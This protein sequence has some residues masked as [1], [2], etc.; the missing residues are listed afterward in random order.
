MVRSME[1]IAK[2]DKERTKEAPLH[3]KLQTKC[4]N[5][6]VH[7]V[8][9][10][11]KNIRLLVIEIVSELSRNLVENTNEFLPL[12]NTIWQPI[13]QRF[14][15]DDFI[16][17]TKI[18][19]L[20]FYLAFLSSDFICS[21]FCK[22]F[23]P[24]LCVFLSEQSKLSLK[25]SHT[26][27]TYIY[28]HAFKLQLAILTSLDQMSVIFEIKELELELLIE[29]CILMY[30]DKRQPKKLQLAAVQ[31]IKN[32]SLIDSDLVW[33]CLHYVMPV[34][35]ICKLNGYSSTLR[36]KYEFSLN[37]EVTSQLTELFKNLES[38]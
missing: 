4:M 37:D 24:R 34:E 36:R 32:C 12:V 18:M 1:A 8:S 16:I 13:C 27:T 5:L 9:H 33:L 29:S 38:Y 2:D 17:K 26:D 14:S 19:R 20:M 3:I 7:L 10:P 31:A 30:L 15:L 21:R 23:L 22:E 6:C 35:A 25:A 11:L 28:S